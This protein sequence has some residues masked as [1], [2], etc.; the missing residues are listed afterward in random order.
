MNALAPWRTRIGP[1]QELETLRERLDRVFGSGWPVF[2]S[3]EPAAWIPAVDL[4]ENDKEFVLTAELPGMKEKDVEIEFDQNMLT[5]KGEKRT[6][7]EE[8]T[9]KN[10]RWHVIE[11]SHGE[12]VR[13]FTLPPAVDPAKTKAE[14]KDGVLTVHLPKRKEA[15]ARKIA[16]SPSK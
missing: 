6:E 9:D 4:K 15:T 8:T 11:R 2:T 7:R 14:F 3:A 10:G 16:I 12:F 13:S 1:W 5:I